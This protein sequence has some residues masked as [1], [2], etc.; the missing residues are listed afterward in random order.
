MSSTSSGS[1]LGDRQHL[2]R[3]SLFAATKPC[4][5][6]VKILSQIFTN[7]LNLARRRFTERAEA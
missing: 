1:V 6:P 4:C 7:Y 3:N 5:S 2:P